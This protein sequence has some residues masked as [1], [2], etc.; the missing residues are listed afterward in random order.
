MPDETIT[1]DPA[2]LRAHAGTLDEIAVAVDQ[3]RA[4]GATVVLGR[5]AYGKLCFQ[6][7]LLMGPI[8]QIG[9]DAL[10][11]AVTALQSTADRLRTVGENYV[12]S[13]EHVAADIGEVI[14][15]ASIRTTG[16]RPAG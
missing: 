8:Q 4:A 6:V 3:A 12:S 7:S 10:H 1:V 11:E 16:S 15:G 14:S 13:D 2:E 5:E 9:V